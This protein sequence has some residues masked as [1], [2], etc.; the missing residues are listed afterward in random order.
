MASAAGGVR[1]FFVNG[2]WTHGSGSTFES[3]NPADGSV[4]A[5]IA[6]AVEPDVDSAVQAARLAVERP[7][8]RDLKPHERARLLARFADVIDQDRDQ[9]AHA[10]MQDNGK[11]VAECRSQ[12]A[13]AAAVVRYHAA[14]CETFEDAITPARGDF[15]NRQVSVS[16]PFGGVKASGLGRE[17][18]IEGMRGYMAQ[19]SIY[20]GLNERPIAWP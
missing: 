7:L 18:G 5:V 13:A 20:L 2:E 6:G 12:A 10:Q 9:L 14:V 3:I 17:K 11:T 15:L 19:K 4:A 8:W 1:P 16:T